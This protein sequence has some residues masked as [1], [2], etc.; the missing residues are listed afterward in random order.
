VLKI[1]F[2][3]SI[4]RS[5]STWLAKAISEELEIPNIGEN[6]YFWDT[7]FRVDNKKNK[8]EQIRDFLRRKGISG[9]TVLDKS[10][11]IYLYVDRLSELNIEFEIVF[12]K[13]NQ[14]DIATSKQ[15]FIARVFSPKR[16][17]MRVKKYYKDYGWKFF[18]P[19]LQKWRFILIPFGL[20]AGSAFNTQKSNH[21]LNMPKNESEYQMFITTLMNNPN[22]PSIDYD[23]FSHSMRSLKNIGLTLDDIDKISATYKG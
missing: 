19:I 12:L 2:L 15:N 11:N 1:I 7:L 17:K 18:I 21:F 3:V 22:C 20:D 8:E 23:D 5:G 13:R 10:T 6:R 16:I 4:G 9:E 14:A